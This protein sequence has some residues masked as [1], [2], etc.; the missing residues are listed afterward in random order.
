MKQTHQWLSALAAL[1]LFTAI[2]AGSAAAQEPSS[3]AGAKPLPLSSSSMSGYQ[4]YDSYR[5][6]AKQ[7]IRERARFEAQQRTLRHEWN[8][9]IGYAPNRPQVNG[10]YMSNG[11][12]YYYIPSRGHIVSTGLARGWYW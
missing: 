9:S 7:Q 4:N 6:A 3:A 12:Q 8:E 11:L 2:S 10:S 1:A 5:E